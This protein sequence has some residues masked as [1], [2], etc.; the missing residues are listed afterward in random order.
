LAIDMPPSSARG[1]IGA[2]K[3]LH[4]AKT[5]LGAC[6]A[7]GRFAKH[8]DA[9]GMFMRACALAENT[10]DENLASFV[11]VAKDIMGIK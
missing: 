5:T 6:R 7:K 3:T 10:R 9:R 11:S 2:E 1:R 8:R 4:A